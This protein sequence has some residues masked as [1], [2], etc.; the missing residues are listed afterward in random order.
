MT[1][2]IEIRQTPLAGLYVI[3]IKKFYD[4]R[5]SLCETFRLSKFKEFGLPTN[6]SQFNFVTSKK[7]V[8]RGLHYQYPNPQG[9]L[10][11]CMYGKI[12]DVAV[13]IRMGSPTFGKWFGLE[14]SDENGLQLYI[15]E[16][17][18]H[19][20][21]VLSDIANVF[22]ATTNEYEPSGQF[23]IIYNDPTINIKW[24]LTG[25]VIISEKDKSLPLITQI[26]SPFK[27]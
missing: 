27:V 26:N 17:Y 4:I 8:I 18:A 6:F 1:Q 2:T 11:C 14:L 9:K 24:P 25:P 10:V 23:G 22:Y 19:G 15:P 21:L 20:Y 16:G 12:F 7:N 3:S 13:D 5:G